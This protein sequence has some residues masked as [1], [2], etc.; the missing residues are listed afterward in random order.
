MRRFL[1]DI[2]R[3]SLTIDVDLSAATSGSSRAP[4]SGHPSPRQVAQQDH[5]KP[6]SPSLPL[7]LA[8]GDRRRRNRT[9]PA[10]LWFG[11]QPKDLGLEEMEDQGVFCKALD[12]DE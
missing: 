7:D 10:L 3:R 4:S 8:A 12:L 1:V 11:P 9:A 5:R 6:L 2:H